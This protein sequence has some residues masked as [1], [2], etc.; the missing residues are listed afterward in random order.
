MFSC[1]GLLGLLADAGW[2]VVVVTAFTQSVA[3]PEG[4]ALAC[5]LDKGLPADVDYMALRRDEDRAACACVGA[6][7]RW[8]PFREAP[9]RGYGSA[10]AL[11]GATLAS[12]DVDAAVAAVLDEVFAELA[13]DLVL[14]PQGIGGHV[15]HVLTVRAM[16]HLMHRPTLWWLDFPY[17]ARATTPD[18]QAGLS[19]T[20]DRERKLRACAA[21][22]T[23]IGFQFGGEDGLAR[24]LK[25]EET[26]RQ[27]WG[28]APNP[29]KG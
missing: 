17:A 4:F 26:F 23:Q 8:L 24:L 15:D 9:H 13:P 20:I 10:G 21:Y 7:A 18:M 22:R 11:F 16:K 2:D 25:A 6:T 28:S 27:D 19:V 1:G 5:Q 12:D 3:A 14:G 29:A